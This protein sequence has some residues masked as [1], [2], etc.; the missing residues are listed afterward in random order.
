MDDWTAGPRPSFMREPESREPSPWTIA[1]GV[2]AGILLAGLIGFVARAWLAQ[3][4][5]EGFQ[6]Q[7]QQMSEQSRRQA[8]QQRLERERIAR[9]RAEAAAA[10]QRAQAQAA[11]AARE[12]AERRERAWN[13]YYRKPRHCDDP[14]TMAVMVE[15]GNEHIR[16]K[17][18]FDELYDAG[19]L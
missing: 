4:A 11:Q 19:K 8:E 14:T 3:R 5:L 13:A 9:L 7:V 17:R 2:A 6:Q 10:Q 16:A 12:E 1:L 18:R 15:C